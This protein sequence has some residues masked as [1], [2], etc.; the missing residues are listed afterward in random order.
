[1]L[2]MDDLIINLCAARKIADH[3]KLDPSVKDALFYLMRG[4]AA[5][6]SWHCVCFGSVDDLKTAVVAASA[7]LTI[8]DQIKTTEDEIE[9]IKKWREMRDEILNWFNENIEKAQ[10]EVEIRSKG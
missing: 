9:T 2:Q 3:T 10:K 4:L 8:A 5:R 1:M 6:F 7:T